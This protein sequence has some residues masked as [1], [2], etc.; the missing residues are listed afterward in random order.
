M[1]NESA[2][3]KLLKDSIS[4]DSSCQEVKLGN[5]IADVKVGNKV[6]EIQTK[7]LYRLKDK[8]RYY[9]SCGYD[10]CVI[11]PLVEHKKYQYKV[12]GVVKK[13]TRRSHV[14]KIQDSLYEIYSIREFIGKI[15]IKI[16]SIDLVDS[17][18]VSEGCALTRKNGTCKEKIPQKINEIWC[19]R[20]T[21]DFKVMIPQGLEREFTSKNFVACSKMKKSYAGYALN[22]L[23]FTGIIKR[24]GHI[25]RCIKYVIE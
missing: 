23:E 19:L 22:V 9:L 16:V 14:G 18:R 25:G 13:E 10:I 20:N 15:E 17:I 5:Y 2:L 12:N 7:D 11:Y 24:D 8:I 4:K 3:H 21:G 6:Y 1:S